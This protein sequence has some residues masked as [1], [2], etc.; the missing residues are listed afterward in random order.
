MLVEI[1]TIGDEILIGQIVDTNS[2]WM[3][4]ALN[5]IGVKVKQIT[6]VSD[7]REHILAALNE[8]S[9]R[10][11]I[12][13]ITG[14]LGPTKDDI[15]KATLCDYFGGGLIFSDLQ[16]AQV[17]K[18]F[19][20]FGREVTEINRKQAEI[21][22]SCELIVNYNGTA[23]GMWFEK[24]ATY[25][26]SMPGVPYEMKAM[27]ETQVIPKIRDA[28]SLPVI[29]HR[30]FLTQGIGESVLSEMITDWEDAL[31]KHMKLAYLPSP[32]MVRLRISAHG[33]NELHVS[34]EI[35]EKAIELYK[36]IGSYIYG[37]GEETLEAIILNI[38]KKDK[39]TLS[40]AESCTG[41]NIAHLLT[42]IPGASDAFV[43]GAIVYTNAMKVDV[44]G[45]NPQTLSNYG[46]VS[47]EVVREMALG[48][49]QKF[50]SDFAIAVSG[51]AGPG[52]DKD[53]NSVGS[54]WIAIAG[55]NFTD[56]K[57]FQFSTNRERNITMS[58]YAA[59]NYLRKQLIDN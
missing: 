49:I 1:I 27:M 42:S 33:E 39:K 18:L 46:V 10:A 48:A 51:V 4:Q 8:A 53:G 11:N 52:A 54:V 47:E 28:F 35:E 3:A 43:G 15:T 6:S 20:S 38:L 5:A 40:L 45:V 55:K 30:T 17:E 25:Y 22:E 29:V 56:A 13:L 14:G 36:H 23:P 44:L 37:E 31:P 9:K 59:L 32:G 16:Y 7:N 12:V 57:K 58:S 2:A 34:S 41:G 21:P 26:M 19:R 24:D 50:N